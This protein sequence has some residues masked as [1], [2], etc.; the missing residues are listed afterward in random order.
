MLRI[1]TLE[2]N[3]LLCCCTCEFQLRH[4]LLTKLIVFWSNFDCFTMHVVLVLL[5]SKKMLL[6]FNCRGNLNSKKLKCSS[7]CILGERMTD[8]QRSKCQFFAASAAHC[9]HS[10]KAMTINDHLRSINESS[11]H[12][13]GLGSCWPNWIL[14][15]KNY[16]FQGIRGFQRVSSVPIFASKC[17]SFL[18]TIWHVFDVYFF[19]LSNVSI[20]RNIWYTSW[21]QCSVV[22]QINKL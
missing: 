1:F 5:N 18:A 20:I 12:T 2:E 10:G 22:A 15:E 9:L 16:Y 4:A 7:W 11:H 21:Q 17:S 19:L 14:T 13:M 6:K 8:R 3:G